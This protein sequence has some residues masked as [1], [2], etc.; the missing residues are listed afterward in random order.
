MYNCLTR[1]YTVV[2]EMSV[3]ELSWN[4]LDDH[5]PPMTELFRNVIPHYFTLQAIKHIN[6]LFRPLYNRLHIS[7][8]LL[9]SCP[10][11]WNH[12]DIS[13]TFADYIIQ[14]SRTCYMCIRDQYL[15]TRPSAGSAFSAIFDRLQINACKQS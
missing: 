5:T 1:W 3:D 7:Y 15:I 8:T 10:K 4:R 6:L 9:F 2:D 14:I 13:L 12:F 11:S